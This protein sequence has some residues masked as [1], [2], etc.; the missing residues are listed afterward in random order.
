MLSLS[1]GLPRP[2]LDC[3]VAQTGRGIGLPLHAA[4]IRSQHQKDLN[5]HQSRHNGSDAHL[6][7][8]TYLQWHL[9]TQGLHKDHIRGE[10]LARPSGELNPQ[11]YGTIHRR[12]PIGP[13][14]APP[15]PR[16]RAISSPSV[17]STQAQI[18]PRA[19]RYPIRHLIS[20]DRQPLL[21]TLIFHLPNLNQLALNP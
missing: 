14:R 19:Y 15:P 16:G 8:T 17:A 1:S 4:E 12:Q 20:R 13:D 21:Q 7:R 10:M 2:R 6:K 5:E 11:L 9:V 18:T 3:S